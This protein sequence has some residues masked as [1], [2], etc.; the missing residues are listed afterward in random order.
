MIAVYAAL[1]IQALLLLTIL[2]L[3][4][5]RWSWR[6][7]AILVVAALNFAV[8]FSVPDTAGTAK[9]S[10]PPDGVL[11]ISCF[12]DEPT[13]IYFWAESE[14]RPVAYRIPYD[15]DTHAACEAAKRASG[16]GVPVGLQRAGAAERRRGYLGRFIPYVLPPSGGLKEGES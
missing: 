1:S 9:R 4:R 15:R 10:G 5:G 8:L 13:Y 7:A 6:A 16:A 12:V 11:F 3:L 2:V 14:G